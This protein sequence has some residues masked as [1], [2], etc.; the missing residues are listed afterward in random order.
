MKRILVS[1][2]IACYEGQQTTLHETSP[3]PEYRDI[4]NLKRFAVT[5]GTSY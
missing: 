1:C 2:S 5:R 4:V 3:D